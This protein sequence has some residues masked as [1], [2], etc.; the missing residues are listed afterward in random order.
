MNHEEYK[1]MLELAAL[2]ALDEAESRALQEHLETCAECR[3]EL[4]ELHVSA[5]ALVYLTEPVE[6]PTELRASI[7]EGI[8]APGMRRPSGLDASDGGDAAERVTEVSSSTQSNVAPVL[9]FRRRNWST[10]TSLVAL[11]ASIVFV[12][13][14]VALFVLWNR[15]RAMQL[16][17]ARLTTR[18][19][20][21]QTELARLSQRNEEMQTELARLSIPKE[22]LPDGIERLPNRNNEPPK[23]TPEQQASKGPVVDEPPVAEPP[24]TPDPD[25]RVVALAGTGRAPQARAS[26]SYNS[27]TGVF[28]LS[29][30][31]LQTPPAGKAYQLWYL[32]KGRPVAGGVFIT[33]PGGQAMMRGPLPP[34][35]R[36]ATAFT[37]TLEP[38]I[39][40]NKPTG[41]KYLLGALS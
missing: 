16:E 3:E 39:G 34:Q 10:A 12:V 21:M 17:L 24:S 7:L 26:L 22:G 33:G 6:A 18:N 9:P 8:R 35:A 38:S 19:Q 15:N 11:A 27:R 41:E 32:V 20:E 30:S 37:V 2:D 25:A 29:V 13:L 40:S 1:A 4:D 28:T 36:G 14:V 31:S 5:A 23:E